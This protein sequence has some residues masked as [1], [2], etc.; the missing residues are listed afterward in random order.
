MAPLAFELPRIRTVGFLWVALNILGSITLVGAQA[1]RKFDLD[2][3][4]NFCSR[5]CEWHLYFLSIA[6]WLRLLEPTALRR[7]VKCYGQSEI[8]QG[9][10]KFCGQRLGLDAFAYVVRLALCLAHTY[11]SFMIGLLQGR[12]AI[13]QALTI[14]CF[15]NCQRQGHI[16]L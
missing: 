9:S 13:L 16:P 7:S 3:I 10:H 15:A 5:W 1:G 8:L 14:C 2:P 4:S 12:T 6:D 11:T